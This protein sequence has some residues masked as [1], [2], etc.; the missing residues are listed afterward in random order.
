VETGVPFVR[1]RGGASDLP[2]AAE[3]SEKR[4]IKAELFQVH[5]LRA[6]YTE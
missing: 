5:R 6:C 4:Y 1:E 3:R 2:V